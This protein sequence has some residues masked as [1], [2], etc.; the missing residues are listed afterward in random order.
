MYLE[1][2]KGLSGSAIASDLLGV[3]QARRRGEGIPGGKGSKMHP[4]DWQ[5]AHCG[6]NMGIRWMEAEMVSARWGINEEIREKGNSI[7]SVL[8]TI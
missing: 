2:R 3:S 5:K 8:G 6:G 4:R 1:V 7:Y